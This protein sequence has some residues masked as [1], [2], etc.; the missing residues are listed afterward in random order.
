M[1]DVAIPNDQASIDE[2]E[3]T[4]P[5]VTSNK[6]K[7]TKRFDSL[8]QAELVDAFHDRHG[9]GYLT[10]DIDGVHHT[11]P[12]ASEECTDFIQHLYYRMTGQGMNRSKLESVLPT[13]SAKAKYD[14]EEKSVFLRVG[15]T[16][17]GAIEL[18]LNDG[19]G[20]CARVDTD[21]WS[22]QQATVKFL[23]PKGLGALPAPTSGGSI[24]RLWELVN[25]EDDTS[26]TLVLAWLV[27]SLRPSGPHGILVLMGDRGSGKTEAM[28]SLRKLIDP[29]TAISKD[30]HKTEKDVFIAAQYNWVMSYD[31]L[32][33]LKGEM[34]DVFCRLSS[35]GAFEDRT[36]Y[37]NNGLTVREACR[38][39]IFNGIV[40]IV[41]RQDLMSRTIPVQ[42][43][44]LH[45]KRRLVSDLEAQFKEA[46]PEILGCLLDGVSS[47]QR[48]VDGV[49]TSQLPRLADFAAFGIAAE[50]ALGLESGSTLA[51]LNET[52]ERAALNALSLDC[53]GEAIIEFMTSYQDDTWQGLISNLMKVSRPEYPSGTWPK[54]ASVFSKQ[55]G[56]IEDAL[57]LRGL[58]VDRGKHTRDGNLITLTK[59]EG[60]EPRKTQRDHDHDHIMEGLEEAGIV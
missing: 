5:V 32:S 47:A 12:V 46:H 37:T 41:S 2:T 39:I 9:I 4:T 21:G 52:Q 6:T 56:R 19:S 55:V 24:D 31:N 26:R 10:V 11:F 14:G 48:N 57:L 38:P 36:L 59:L 25:V 3:N 51:A 29:A 20:R 49:D 27:G 30:N 35:G 42:F 44:R 34:S 1:T 17:D 22:V 8:L 23:R 18:D 43:S 28:K 58:A 33:F 7:A 40:D 45:G 53:V 50:E 54:D 16:E 15:Q 60:F 13:L